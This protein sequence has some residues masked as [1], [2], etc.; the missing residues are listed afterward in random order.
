M[1][2]ITVGIGVS[3]F[4]VGYIT[5]TYVNAVKKEPIVEQ[6]PSTVAV[7]TILDEIRMFDK[8]KLKKMRNTRPC[9]K[10][11]KET[12]AFIRTKNDELKNSI[13]FQALLLR[14]NLM[15]NKKN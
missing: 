6:Q 7:P 3:S 1:D 2:P 10:P 4:V 13:L 9:Q 15:L 5:S 14:R 8:S 11:I 12:P